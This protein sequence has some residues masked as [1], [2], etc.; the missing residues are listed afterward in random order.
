RTRC[1]LVDHHSLVCI[2]V[3]MQDV[4][5]IGASKRDGTILSIEYD[6]KRLS[7]GHCQLSREPKFRRNLCGGATRLGP[8]NQCMIARPSQ[9]THDA[10][11]RQYDEKL[12]QSPTLFLYLSLSWHAPLS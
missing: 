8:C 7:P 1:W 2:L 11:D 4:L 9:H 12:C 5:G 10:Q 3:D 6:P